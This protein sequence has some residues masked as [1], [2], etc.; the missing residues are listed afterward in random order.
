MTAEA[1][2]IL[3]NLPDDRPVPAPEGCRTVVR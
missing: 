1:A 2:Q 3:C